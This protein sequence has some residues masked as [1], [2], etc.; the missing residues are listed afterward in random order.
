[1]S[2]DGYVHWIKIITRCE[3]M[4]LKTYVSLIANISIFP[5][6]DATYGLNQAPSKVLLAKKYF[7]A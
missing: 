7:H 6:L 5:A 1:M 4:S 2:N 3:M